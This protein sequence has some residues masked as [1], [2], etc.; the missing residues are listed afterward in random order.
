LLLH[1]RLVIRARPVPGVEADL[2]A[3]LRPA[4]DPPSSEEPI[5]M[6][7]GVSA[8]DHLEQCRSRAA[9]RV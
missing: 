2:R 9:P 3:F 4:T 5:G 8:V 7:L 6:A 1:A